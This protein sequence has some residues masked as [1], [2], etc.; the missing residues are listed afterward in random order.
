M[1]AP[2]GFTIVGNPRKRRGLFASID[3]N[4]IRFTGSEPLTGGQWVTV[5]VNGD[6]FAVLFGEDGD[7]KVNGRFIGCS[8]IAKTFDQDR[9]VGAKQGDW[10]IFSPVEE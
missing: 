1:E 2:E 10:W 8:T 3:I 5:A 9:F 6:K 7:Y 4:G